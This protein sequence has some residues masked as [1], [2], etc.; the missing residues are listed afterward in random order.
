M[1]QRDD[2]ILISSE[3]DASVGD[4]NAADA[5][6]PVSGMAVAAAVLG[7]LSP[8]AV[9]HPSLFILPVIG[10]VFAV[11]AIRDLSAADSIKIG[12]LAALTGL[13]LSLFFGCVGLTRSLTTTWTANRRA[14]Q[15]A[16]RWVD[17]VL[18]GRI[19]E[20]HAMLMPFQRV[21]APGEAEGN[22]STGVFD[23]KAIEA[24]YRQRPEVAAILTC[25]AAKRQA[26]TLLEYVPESEEREEVWMVRVTISPCG[27]GESLA[28]DIEVESALVKQPDAWLEQWQVKN[29]SVT[30]QSSS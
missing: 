22:V 17:A 2:Q 13:A 27:S 3:H 11:V 12:R 30:R 15:V 18:D 24:V 19:L 4:P 8:A 21:N 28:L 6:R 29:V 1:K 7:V 16:A 20:A 10:A 25:G 9:I 5:Y 26:A 23:S 14:E